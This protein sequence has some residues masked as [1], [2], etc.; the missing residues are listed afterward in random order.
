MLYVKSETTGETLWEHDGVD[1]ES[2][3]DALDFITYKGFKYIRM[4]HND[5]RMIY[6]VK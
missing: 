4:E 5:K 1:F 6:W 3:D 2:M